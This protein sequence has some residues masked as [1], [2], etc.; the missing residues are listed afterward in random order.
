MKNNLNIFLKLNIL[1]VA[2]NQIKKPLKLK[3]N[4]PIIQMKTSALIMQ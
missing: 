3:E 1:I 2:K 4:F